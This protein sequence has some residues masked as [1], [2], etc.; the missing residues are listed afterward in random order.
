[1]IVDENRR[2]QHIMTMSDGVNKL[3]QLGETVFVRKGTFFI[4]AGKFYDYIYIVKEGIAVSCETYYNGKV[5]NGLLMPK[6]SIIGEP[7]VILNEPSPVSFKAI[8]DCRL[9][10]IY[11]SDLTEYLKQNSELY[12]VLIESLS[13]KLLSTMDEVRQMAGCNVTWRVCNLL[14]V[15]AEHYGVEINGKV[16]IDIPVSQQHIAWMLYL[17]RITVVRVFKRLQDIKL[18]EKTGKRYYITDLKAFK[19]YMEKFKYDSI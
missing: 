17:N 19:D 14:L 8:K 2:T 3:M 7:F 10:R 6:G 13:K 1:M 12:N 18:L 4:Q 15:F 9:V 5:R 16:C 11:L